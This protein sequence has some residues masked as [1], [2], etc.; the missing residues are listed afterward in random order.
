MSDLVPC[1]LNLSVAEIRGGKI[2]ASNDF[3]R[4]LSSFMEQSDFKELSDRYISDNIDMKT[5]VM[6]MNLYRLAGEHSLN[7]TPNQKIAFIKDAMSDGGLRHKIVNEALK[8][9]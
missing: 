5:V 4:L 3:F 9:S 7:L 8:S 6:Y 2:C 1:N